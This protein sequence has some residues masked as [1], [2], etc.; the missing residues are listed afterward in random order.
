MR[1]NAIKSHLTST[2]A[3]PD[4]DAELTGCLQARFD[5]G[6]SLVA[7]MSAMRSSDNSVVAKEEP[8]KPL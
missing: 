6:Q 1:T 3:M 7:V 4:L 5:R 2:T 8:R